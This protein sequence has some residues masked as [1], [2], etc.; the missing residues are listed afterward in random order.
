MH[1]RTRQIITQHPHVLRALA[2]PPARGSC[3]LLLLLLLLCLLCLLLLLLLLL[4][5]EVPHVT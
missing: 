3:P 1:A 2:S 4:L 5:L